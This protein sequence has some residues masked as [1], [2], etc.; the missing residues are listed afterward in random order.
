MYPEGTEADTGR[1]MQSPPRKDPG[2]P[3]EL[4]PWPRFCEGPAVSNRVLAHFAPFYQATLVGTSIVR[5]HISS[6][7]RWAS[8]VGLS[9]SE[10]NFY[11]WIYVLARGASP[12]CHFDINSVNAPDLPLGP[13]TQKHAALPSIVGTYTSSGKILVNSPRGGLLSTLWIW[14]NCQVDKK[15]REHFANGSWLQPREGKKKNGK[16]SILSIF[17]KKINK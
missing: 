5:A 10:L 3:S 15:G 11:R 13:S 2:G 8:T 16:W 6:S 17:S 9:C 14:G 1:N 12:L 7:T 4:N